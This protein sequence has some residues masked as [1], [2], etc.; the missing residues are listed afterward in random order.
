[1]T[2][3]A[4]LLLL[5]ALA[6]GC[7]SSGGRDSGRGSRRVDR[8]TIP[9]RTDAGPSIIVPP[10]PPGPLPPRELCVADADCTIERYRED[11]GC[12]TCNDGYGPW[13]PFRAVSVRFLAAR[14]AELDAQRP[15]TPR[16]PGMCN[17][18]DCPAPF[19]CRLEPGAACRAGR[20]EV[21][22]RPGPR[23]GPGTCPARCGAR[24]PLTPPPEAG[25]PSPCEAVSAFAWLRCCCEA[26]GGEQ[27]ERLERGYRGGVGCVTK[28]WPAAVKAVVHRRPNPSR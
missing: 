8:P 9:P 25:R 6:A 11:D 4:L 20:C 22:V 14:Q 21:V 27:C 13:P 7:G 23:C 19:A 3:R 16:R 24:P 18:L 10:R 26:L 2:P 12:P 1:M 28:Q 5:S 15:P 17:P